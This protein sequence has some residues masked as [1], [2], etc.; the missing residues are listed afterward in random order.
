MKPGNSPIFD[1]EGDRGR[2]Y[3]WLSELAREVIKDE[4]V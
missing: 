4:L 3:R 1:T 2:Y